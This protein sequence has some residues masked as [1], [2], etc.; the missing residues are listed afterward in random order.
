MRRRRTSKYANAGPFATLLTG[1][2]KGR[3]LDQ[4]LLIGKLEFTIPMIAEA[5]NLTYKTVQDYMRHLEKA[6]LVSP[7]RKIGNAQAY[8]FNIENHMSGLIQWATEFQS[9]RNGK[10]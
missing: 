6:E 4:S 9:S 7:T 10:C 3:I 8:Q 1:D 5:T 2:P